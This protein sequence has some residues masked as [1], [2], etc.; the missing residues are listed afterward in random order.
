MIFFGY[1][2]FQIFRISRCTQ[3]LIFFG[4]YSSWSL[5]IWEFPLYFKL[6]SIKKKL[7]FQLSHSH[8]LIASYTCRNNIWTQHE[9]WKLNYSRKQI[10]EHQ[11]PIL[12]RSRYQILAKVSIFSALDSV[13][14]LFQ[15]M[16]Y[17][18]RVI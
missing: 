10:H 1:W 9:N 5:L 6:F 7:F 14:F 2:I 12:I 11:L 13:V 18:Y 8:L 3:F 15:I 16:F 17:L 4:K